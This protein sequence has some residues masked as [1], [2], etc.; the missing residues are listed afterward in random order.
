MMTLPRR[1]RQGKPREFAP[2]ATRGGTTNSVRRVTQ[3][4]GGIA[5]CYFDDVKVGDEFRSANLALTEADIIN[6][7]LKY[8]PQSFHV[9]REAASRSFYSGIIASGWKTCVLAHRLYVDLVPWG[10]NNMGSPGMGEFRLPRPV[11]PGDAIRVV[12]TV[13]EAR[14]SASRPACGVVTQELEVLN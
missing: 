13:L 11:H 5:G 7:A 2:R 9:D 10:D 1:K 12:V 6:F 14:P 8:D 4:E 3:R